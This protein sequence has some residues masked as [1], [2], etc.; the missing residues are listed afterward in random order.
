M[1]L[2][3]V[4]LDDEFVATGDRSGTTAVV[5]ILGEDRLVV[6]NVGDS[7]AIL[8][9]AGKVVRCGRS[10]PLPRFHALGYSVCQR[11]GI[12]G[13]YSCMNVP[14]IHVLL[15]WCQDNALIGGYGIIFAHPACARDQG[16]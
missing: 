1:P 2:L 6:A 8:C 4:Q 15:L 12:C 5:A 11:S 7:K 13:I 9:N 14:A 16:P 3:N 10:C